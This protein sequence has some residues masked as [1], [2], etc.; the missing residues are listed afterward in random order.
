M[1]RGALGLRTLE[2]GAPGAT[3]EA[4]SAAA[5]LALAVQTAASAC[6]VSGA[7]ARK[8][9]DRVAALTPAAPP[10]GSVRPGEPQSHSQNS[11]TRAKSL[12]FNH[13]RSYTDNRVFNVPIGGK[14]PDVDQ[15]FEDD[16]QWT[17]GRAV[18]TLH[19]TGRRGYTCSAAA[20][21]LRLIQMCVRRKM[22]LQGEK[23]KKSI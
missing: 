17:Q 22:S 6:L 10:L 20:S 15:M 11:N 12:R 21:R 14:I 8:A 2:R 1:T 4:G 3:R 7:L 23:A 16:E 5:N 13:F 9:V 18:S 19:Y